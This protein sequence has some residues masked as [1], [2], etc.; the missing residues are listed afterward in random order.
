MGPVD[1]G[2][3]QLLSAYI[4]VV[5]LMLIL[6][7]RRIPREKEV[8][9]ASIRMTFQL[10]MAGFVLSYIL[11]HPSPLYTI[12]AVLVMEIFAIYNVYKRARL[13]LPAR[14]KKRLELF[15]AISVST[16]TLLS[17]VYFLYV[18]VR[19]SPWFDPRY[20]IPLAGMIIGNSMTGVSLGVKTLSESITIQKDIVEAALMLGARPKDAVRMFSDRAFDS[21]ILP[22]LNSMIGMGIVFLPGMMTGQILSGASPITAIKYQ[23]AIMLGILGGVTISVSVFLYL[24]YKAFFNRENQLI[25]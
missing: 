21:A 23:I 11:D 22:T 20:V 19:I 16:G 3:I 17:L 10:V 24:G 9:V 18:V 15:I 5:V 25:V 2:L 4:F 1:I 8:L 12:L 7:I 14:V 13:S 6:R